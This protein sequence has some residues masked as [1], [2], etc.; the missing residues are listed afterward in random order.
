MHRRYHKDTVNLVLGAAKAGVAGPSTDLGFW[1]INQK[2]RHNG[3][4]TDR[5]TVDYI[6]KL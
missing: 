3:I 1:I 2:L 5:E 4:K 6:W